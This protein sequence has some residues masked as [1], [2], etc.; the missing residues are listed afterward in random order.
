[1]ANYIGVESTYAL[2]S[3]RAGLH[4]KNLFDYKDLFNIN[5]RSY[6]NI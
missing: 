1:M 5:V 2:Y 4:L 3:R 6:L